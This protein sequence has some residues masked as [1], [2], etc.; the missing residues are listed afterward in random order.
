[1]KAKAQ[2]KSQHTLG[3]AAILAAPDN[4]QAWWLADLGLDLQESIRLGS[5]EADRGEGIPGDEV[6]ARARKRVGDHLRSRSLRR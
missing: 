2:K 1:M 4:K 3:E 5:E 6:I